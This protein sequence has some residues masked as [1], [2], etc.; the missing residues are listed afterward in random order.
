MLTF[1]ATAI[2]QSLQRDILAKRKKYDKSNYD[3]LFFS[4]RNHKCEVFPSAI[5]PQERHKSVNAIFNLLGI[6]C[7]VAILRSDHMLC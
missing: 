2:I 6:S 4:L 5:I 7:P 1:I 3:N